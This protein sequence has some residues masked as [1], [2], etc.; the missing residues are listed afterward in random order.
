MVPSMKSTIYVLVVAASL[1]LA[2]YQ[3]THPVRAQ[4]SKA[5]G[6]QA[7]HAVRTTAEKLWCVAMSNLAAV[8]GLHP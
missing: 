3:P 7:A 8:N 1:L 2:A 5:A 6:T 4:A